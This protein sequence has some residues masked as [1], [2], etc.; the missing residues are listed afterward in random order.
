MNV[1]SWTVVTCSL[2]HGIR[3]SALHAEDQAEVV[4]AISLRRIGKALSYPR[5]ASDYRLA[6]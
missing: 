3:E 5:P 6:F 4:S 2:A 1:S